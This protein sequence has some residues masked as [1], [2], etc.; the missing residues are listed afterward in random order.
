[1]KTTRSEKIVVHLEPIYYKALRQIMDKEGLSAS[2][3]G[4]KAVISY[5]LS[6]GLITSEMIAEQ[7]CQ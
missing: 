3:A 1:M 2:S 4:R 7:V 5:L 6:I